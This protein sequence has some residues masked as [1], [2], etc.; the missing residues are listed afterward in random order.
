[1]LLGLRK[2]SSFSFLHLQRQWKS[3]ALCPDRWPER[4]YRGNGHCDKN[5]KKKRKI[6][7]GLQVSPMPESQSCC[8]REMCPIFRCFPIFSSHWPQRKCSTRLPCDWYPRS[9]VLASSHPWAQVVNAGK[10]N[11]RQSN[12]CAGH[13]SLGM[14]KK[15]WA[16]T[17]PWTKVKEYSCTECPGSRADA[18]GVRGSQFCEGQCGHDDAKNIIFPKCTFSRPKVRCQFWR[19]QKAE[20]ANMTLFKFNLMRR[21]RT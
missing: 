14:E 20:I 5:S 21:K 6:I 12:L 1:M 16:C 4:E 11:R 8:L 9:F 3:Q 15:G 2:I 13:L 7:C 19:R 17:S 10:D 18:F